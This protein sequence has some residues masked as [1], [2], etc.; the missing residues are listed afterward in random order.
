MTDIATL[1]LAVDSSQVKTASGDLR[2]LESA[3]KRAGISVDEMRS[4]VEKASS[5]IGSSGAPA[6]AKYSEATNKVIQSLA[7]QEVRLNSTAKEWAIIQNLQRAG[8][9]ATS[10][11]GQKIALVTGKLYDQ[12]QAQKQLKAANDNS[13][14]SLDRFSAGLTKMLIVG[15]I[16][17]GVRRLTQ[18]MFDLTGQLAKMG[19]VSQRLGV[20]TG[21]FQGLELV[22]GGAGIGSD[23]FLK[24]FLKFGQEVDR[25]KVGVGDL[26]KLLKANG[27]SAGGVEATF[28]KVADL[29][30]NARSDMNKFSLLQQAGLPATLQWVQ[31]M[32]Q[33]GASLRDAAEEARKLGVVTDDAL[34][35]RAQSFD[36]EWTKALARLS[37]KFRA[38]AADVIGWFS[39]ISSAGTAALIKITSYLPESIRPDI[40]KNILR[41]SMQDNAG[42]RL[43]QNKA[44]EFYDAVGIGDNGVKTTIDPNDTIKQQK[45]AFDSAVN[46]INRHIAAMQAD[47][48]A[49]GLSVGEHAKLRVEAQLVEAG[50]RGGLSRAA[51]EAS[52][53]YKQLGQ[54]AADAAQKLALARLASD[55]KFDRSQIGLSDSEASANAQI[56]RIFGDDV[57]SAQAQFYKQQLMINDALRQYSD[58]GKDAT[59]GFISDIIAGKN[60]LESL[61]N[62]LTKIGNKLIDMAMDGLWGKAFGGSGGIGGVLGTLFGGG[63]PGI[64]TTSAVAGAS[65]F[66]MGGISFPKFASGTDFAPG[67]WSIV[68]EQGP[69]LLRLPRGAGVT[70]NDNLKQMFNGGG[71]TVH[72]GNTVVNISGNADKQTI[73]LMQQEL[74]K[75]D[76]DFSARVEGA[77]RKAQ[78]GR[79]L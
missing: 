24:N 50:M 46:S 28:F 54:A 44:N 72:G 66:M 32:E 48:D 75:R 21:K 73:A 39:D 41:A 23:E 49:V 77:V 13:A 70:S 20:S 79:R 27:E 67:G 53:K 18:Y 68:G 6:Q 43:S 17:E 38:F 30:K 60:A 69:E 42:T 16:A 65:S 45:T 26:N 55:I 56:R 22:A 7:M 29:I 11:V 57:T 10:E 47:A 61:G 25:A 8:V 5:S 31:L 76:A 58:I 3:A 15:V 64:G 40:G 14:S 1:G 35:R 71:V 62:A 52:E 4:R 63:G 33:G 59:K 9:S 37:L 2:N 51:V 74:A 34:I 19:D 78:Q 12:E 36:E